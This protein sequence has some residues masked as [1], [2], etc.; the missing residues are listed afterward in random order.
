M[1][2]LKEIIDDIFWNIRYYLVYYPRNVFFEIKYFIQRGRR[3]YSDRDC[4]G[5]SD[6]LSSILPGMLRSL[7]EERSIKREK[8]WDEL[9]E[10]MAQGFEADI[11]ANK[12]FGKELFLTDKHTKLKKQRDESLKLLVKYYDSLWS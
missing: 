12:M 5:L 6:H 9:L 7:K 10:S 2:K 11:K 3:G 8:G 1:K 4:W